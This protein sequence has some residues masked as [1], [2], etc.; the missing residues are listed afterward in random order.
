MRGGDFIAGT[1]VIAIPK[2]VLLA[3]LVESR[4]RYTFTS[5]Q[6]S[7]YGTFE[8]QILEELLRRP[9]SAGTM[10]L[11]E[12]GMRQDLR[13]NRVAG[14]QF[15]RPKYCPSSPNSTPRSAP[16]SSVSGCSGGVARIR[17]S[18]RTDA[19]EMPVQSNTLAILSISTP[20][21]A[22]RSW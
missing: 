21:L 19:A 2:R 4:N 7:A 5:Q 22:T 12:D 6:L 20:S 13:Q 3:D 16:S 9:R 1:V 8:L 11:L 15:L 14:A 18:R 10:A 17:T